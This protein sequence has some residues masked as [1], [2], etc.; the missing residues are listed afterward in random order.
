MATPQDLLSTNSQPTPSREWIHKGR[1]KHAERELRIVGKT[2]EADAAAVALLDDYGHATDATSLLLAHQ[3][4]P[5]QHR[6]FIDAVIG[7]VR[8]SA[9]EADAGG[10]V[11]IND[12]VLAARAGKCTKTVAGWR[13]EFRQWADHTAIMEIK[14]HYREP[15]GTPHPHAYKVHI[16]KLAVEAVLEARRS[17]EWNN[18]PRATMETTAKRIGDSAPTFTARAKKTR[19]KQSDVEKLDSKM[20]QAARLI[21]EV[22]GLIE[23][24]NFPPV[25]P[26]ME[27]F[28]QSIDRLSEVLH[29]ANVPQISTLKDSID[30]VE[31]SGDVGGVVE[32]TS[33]RG[34]LVESTTYE[35]RETQ[36]A[37]VSPDPV[38]VE[39]AAQAVEA[40]GVEQY[41]L[42]VLDDAAPKGEAAGFE[43]LTRGEL[44]EMLPALL[45]RSARRGRSVI[46]R[47]VA[48]NLIQADDLDRAAVERV[49]HFAFMAVE[50]SAG[51]YQAWIA[52]P[53]DIGKDERDALR[54]RLLDGVGADRGASGAMRWPGSINFKAGRGQFMVRLVSSN[55]GRVATVAELEASDMLAPVSPNLHLTQPPK[56]RANRAPVQ[57]P[58]YQRCV[59]EA[60]RKED[61]SP[62]MSDADKNWCILALDRGWPEIE[63][64][65]KLRELRDK[66]RK[67]PEYARRTVA[68]ARS[69]V[70]S[71]V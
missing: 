68:Y 8:V 28:R 52:L 23:F 59:N 36:P 63:V 7:A 17:P 33:T 44:S 2:D 27:T 18:D 42:T 71:R 43:T 26:T 12:K 38:A 3:A 58:D 25:T 10:F 5:P 6:A 35:N 16:D 32:K 70:N 53:F 64:E 56:L 14:E 41:Q 66:A 30:R 29:G 65:S 57:W 40:C 37:P 49:Q 46:V 20:R 34:D 61:G 55:P 51:N 15:D 62:D 45:Q 1:R 4:C 47:P 39:M 9:R 13:D 19:R 50:T 60:K 69:V 54:R 67:R 11:E 48:S 31:I 24:T 22:A 21:D